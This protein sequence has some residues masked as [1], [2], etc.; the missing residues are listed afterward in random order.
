MTALAIILFLVVIYRIKSVQLPLSKK[1]VEYLSAKNTVPLKGALAL[2]V[3]SHHCALYLSSISKAL[4]IADNFLINNVFYYVGILAVSEFFF[5]SGY[6]LEYSFN[7]KKDYL[8]NFFKSKATKILLPFLFMFAV[9][10]VYYLAADDRTLLEILFAFKN[11]TAFVMYSWYIIALLYFYVTFYISH[12]AA[13]NKSMQI[14]LFAIS[15]LAYIF[16]MF[17]LNRCLDWGKHWMNSVPSILLGVIWYHIKPLTL[18]LKNSTYFSTLIAATAMFAVTCIALTKFVFDMIPAIIFVILVTLLLIKFR[19]SNKI[20]NFIGKISFELYMLQGV[21]LSLTSKL[22]NGVSKQSPIL[23]Q[24]L[25]IPCVFITATAGAYAL[26]LL[27]KRI[28]YS[29]NLNKH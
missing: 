18:K 3:L 5:L 13:Q 11:G 12:K 24:Y 29:K 27:F 14:F 16:V 2:L 7:N 4:S 20:L 1:D 6:G 28:F 23:F 21:A 17:V 9:Y 15:V 22:L 8:N 19:I 10:A 26:N 25:F